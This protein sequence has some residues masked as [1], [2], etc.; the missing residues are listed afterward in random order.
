MA[1]P[2]SGSLK[3]SQELLHIE[4]DRFDL[5]IQG[6][7]FHPSVEALQLHRKDEG[8]WVAST[9][10]IVPAPTLTIKTMKLF[11]PQVMDLLPLEENAAF[12]IFFE[13]QEYEIVLQNKQTEPLNFYHENLHLRQAVK[14]LGKDLLVGILNFRNEVGYTDLEIR[15]Q[16]NTLLSLRLEIF[17]AKMDYRRDY[18]GILFEVNEQIYNLAFD[19]L[20]RTY[21]LTGL[22]D[23]HNQSLTE[24]FTILR[25][26]FGQLGRAIERIQAAPHHRLT[27]IREV[28]RAEQVKRVDK[29]NSSYLAKHLQRL[30][31]DP[32]YGLI[33]IQGKYFRPTH[34]WEARRQIN[35]DTQEN[36]FLKWMFSRIT[37]KLKELRRRVLVMERITDPV[38]L[39]QIDEMLRQLDRFSEME[40]LRDVGEIKQ[41]SVTLV[42]QMASGYRDVYRFYLL[43]MKG[44]TI[45]GDLFRLSLKDLAQLYEY[46]C[47]LKI[48]SLLKQ[49]YELVRQDIIRVNQQGLFVIL[50]RSQKASVTYRN[51]LND[52]LFTLFYN[53]LP[54][55]DK[56]IPTLAQR[57]DNVLALK[58]EHSAVEY[59]YIFDAKYR[60]N[61][62]YEGTPYG[63]KYGSPGPEEEDINTMHRY[64]D[65]IVYED[66][67]TKEYQRSMFG[68]Y[69]LFPYA[70]EEEFR[71]HRFY[72]SIK[73]VNVG[74]FP[75]LPGATKLMEEFLDELILDSPEKAF[76]RSTQ[77]RGTK[78]YYEDKLNGKNVLIGS[79]RDKQQL[80]LC[81]DRKQYWIPLKGLYQEQS[82]LTQLEYI[83]LY[84]SNRAFGPKESGV[85]WI[86]QIKTW[87]VVRRKEITVRKPLPGKENELYVLFEINSWAKRT[88]PIKPG[89]YGI[90]TYLFTSTYI[91][92]RAQFIAEL[93]LETEEELKE[94]REKRRLGEIHVELDDEYVDKASRVVKVDWQGA[95][96]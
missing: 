2:H 34:L 71:E 25:S 33:P 7:P 43:L 87:S 45:Q 9:L 85:W 77:P 75:F 23:T 22:R 6:K 14:P 21:Q 79:M 94:W 93:K 5:Y 37:I 41:I 1:L 8:E 35:Y 96:G 50:D 63:L 12:P 26:I 39:K 40:F 48:H 60:L 55:E 69:I 15:S 70:D 74:A 67:K 59:K 51:P 78:Q 88:F 84:Q 56:N 64:R 68:A 31:E 49:K 24:F 29:S 53:A 10:Q 90:Q 16:G 89:G 66:P 36:R 18:Q 27:A 83:G 81:L 20:R 38:L 73:K 17:P 92:E 65:A 91:L 19:F 62:A 95:E 28:R 80:S 47:F 76:E 44:L 72:K 57:P 42:L 30:V 13:N 46:W 54:T 52:E 3:E 58:K 82:I 4:T 11:S 61:P 86:G 32:V